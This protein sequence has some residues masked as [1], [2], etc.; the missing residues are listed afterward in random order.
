MS[1]RRI[2]Q[3]IAQTQKTVQFGTHDLLFA[4]P[5]RMGH[6]ASSPSPSALNF[7]M[8]TVETLEPR[9]LLSADPLV[10]IWQEIEENPDTPQITIVTPETSES[11]PVEISDASIANMGAQPAGSLT[12]KIVYVYAG[13]GYDDLGSGWNT[14]R[15]DNGLALVE[16]FGNQDQMTMLVDYLFNAGATIVPLRPIG[17]QTNEVV[18]D[19]DDANVQFVGSWSNSSSTIFWG[20]PGDLPYRFASTNA[21]ETAYARYTPNIPEAGNYPVYTW[22]RYGSDRVDQLYKVTHSGGT[23][24]VRVDHTMVGNG[25][26]Y[27]GTYHFEAGTSG[28]VDISNQS[29]R[30]GVIIADH[31]R[32]GN[33][34]GDTTVGGSTISGQSREDEDGLY[35]SFY[36]TNNAQG[37]TSS[38]HGTGTVS[39]APRFASYMNREASG[40]LSDR[41]FLSYHSNAFNGNS[42]GVIGLLN[43]NNRA[44]A[45]TPNM[46]ELAFT[47]AKEINDD[48]V[49]QNG[50]FEHNWADRGNNLTLDSGQFEYGEINNELIGNEFD[51]TI[52]ETGF[53]DNQLDAEMLRDARVRDA[54][55]RATYQGLVKYFND[56]DNGSTPLVYLPGEVQDVRAAANT[57]GSVTLNWTPPSSNSY[58]GSA[59]TGYRI[60]TSSNGKGF[61]A[62]I[63][64]SGGG[65]NTFTLT[66]LTPGEVV[67][68]KVAATNT[69]G[70]S[71][72]RHV[73]AAQPT[74]TAAPRVLIVNGFDRVDRFI[75][76][77]EFYFSAQVDRPRWQQVNSFDYAVQHAAAIA[78]YNS[79]V[80]ID[81]VQ[82]QQI[83]SGAVDLGDY[84][85]VIWITGQESTNNETFSNTE[86]SLVTAYV[87][88][89]GNL[90]VSGSEIGWDLEQFSGGVSFYQNVLGGDYLSDDAGTYTASGTSGSIF[91][92]ISLNF[93]NGG[94]FTYDV[95]FPDRITAGPGATVAMNYIG[96]SGGGAAVTKQG[97][98]GA[99]NVVMFGFP[100]EMINDVADRDAIMAASLDFFNL[101]SAPSNDAGLVA[102][103]NFDET[104]G[105][106]AVDTSSEGQNNAGTLT[107]DATL[108]TD[109]IRSSSGVAFSGNGLVTI[110][111]SS[112]INTAIQTN[113]TISLWFRAD[114]TTGRQMIYE[115]GGVTRGLNIYLDNDT[116][117]AGGWNTSTAQ[118]AWAGTW[119]SQA[120]INA[121]QWYQVSLVLNG[122]PTIGAGAITVYVD[123]QL[124]G[125]GNGSQVWGANGGIGIGDVNGGTLMHDGSAN[126]SSNV[127]LSGRVDDFRVYNRSLDATE[128]NAIYAPVPNPNTPTTL[129]DFD[130]STSSTAPDTAPTGTANNGTL[131]GDATRAPGRF[132][133]GIQLGGNGYVAVANGNDLNATQSTYTVSFWFKA[134]AGTLGSGEK[135]LWEQG[136]G[137]RGMNIYL[138]GNTL[139]AGAW[140]QVGEPEESF[141]FVSQSGIAED[142][143]IHVAMVIDADTAPTPDGLRLYIDGQLVATANSTSIVGN[144]NPN[145]IGALNSKTRNVAGTLL[146]GTGTR[147]FVGIIDQFRVDS[148]V[149]SIA[150]I[151][152]LAKQSEVVVPPPPLVAQLDLN[153]GSGTTAADT[154]PDGASYPGTLNG[155]AAFSDGGI[156]NGS[157]RFNGNGYMALPNGGDINTADQPKLTLSM[158]IRVDS[159]SGTQMIY[160]Q[161]GLTRGLN[162]YIDNGTLYA[163]AW[164][165]NAAES[166]WSGDWISTAAISANTWHH[167]TLRLDAGPTLEPDSMSLFLDGVSVGTSQASQVFRHGGVIGVGAVNGGTRIHTG[168]ISG[169]GSLAYTGYVDD[170]RIYR[171]VLDDTDIAGLAS[172]S[173]AIPS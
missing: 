167:V 155:D 94:L 97:T 77:K 49:D 140:S 32:F 147:G 105:S 61:D 15:G 138:D 129:I 31:I 20:S 74:D 110:G 80:R 158:W 13:H 103:L 19:N 164:N 96:G 98:N 144:D 157:L 159:T 53:H 41:V 82:N 21:T 116:L 17:H 14:Q 75:S 95:R 122:G 85:A 150:E 131:V 66:G 27:L 125:S 108:V 126:A 68:F 42:R 18:I 114:S 121:D 165:D 117:Y 36:Q 166:N 112:D 35:W 109:G 104:L 59:P 90:F 7:S 45:A 33:G 123:G 137:K 171:G 153:D 3:F 139:Y 170:L 132:G 57:N 37:I 143:W 56:V 120:G 12:G 134:D 58:N 29:N 54:I 48:L 136:G 78:N 160:E 146:D 46:F 39:S 87:N 70:E 115:H 55:A 24:E 52:I 135:I 142:T 9:V 99:G 130:Q 44:S 34:F 119:I 91:D 5:N 151:D 16:D 100:F 25:Y 162:I 72:A 2:R 67:Y 11:Q 51:A 86:Q 124:V 107:G 10:D 133:N 128:A 23:T 50:Q 169:T 6:H 64:V 88:S 60:Y 89:G 71:L 76:T 84:Q 81:T 145:A 22:T 101:Q 38:V 30:S 163:G 93:S 168:E 63:A 69:A 172:G 141:A 152:G 173:P 62:G 26:V 83:E 40:T 106:N 161:G 149:L 43:G 148:R 1:Y 92:G 111:N 154:S 65:T 156:D 4:N 47:V 113:Q 28:Y 8:K 102:N 118:S 73:V 127:G 79:D